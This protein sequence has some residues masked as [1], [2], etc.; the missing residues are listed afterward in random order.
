MSTLYGAV[1]LGKPE[2]QEF[3]GEARK[4]IENY[5]T[6]QEAEKAAEEASMQSAGDVPPMSSSGL[7]Q[8]DFD[9]ATQMANILKDSKNEMLKTEEGRAQYQMGLNELESFLADRKTY[10]R[11]THPVLVQNTKLKK[12]GIT[13]EAWQERGQMDGRNL[14]DY[15]SKTAELDTNRFSV[16]FENGSFVLSDVDGDHTWN[17]PT[18]TDLSWFDESNFLIDSPPIS[19]QSFYNVN[20]PLNEGSVFEDRDAV[21]DYVQREVLKDNSGLRVRD[22]VRWYVNSE[23]NQNSDEPLTFEQIMDP[24]NQNGRERVVAAYAE[25]AV[26]EGWKPTEK[27]S[28]SGSS[29]GSST[30][31]SE[32][33]E[34][35]EVY[36]SSSPDAGYYEVTVEGEKDAYIDQDVATVDMPKVLAINAATWENP[37]VDEGTAAFRVSGMEF[38]AQK[39]FMIITSTGERVKIEAN[40]SEFNKLKTQVDDQLGKGAFDKMYKE[41]KS[42]A[43]EHSGEIIPDMTQWRFDNNLSIN[44]LEQ[45]L[46]T[47]TTEVTAR[48]SEPTKKKERGASFWGRLPF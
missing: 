19:P 20:K 15:I 32:G 1:D 43:L 41:L 24:N 47:E 33:F 2:R 48:P 38:S 16:N 26:D 27:E 21:V 34:M 45:D 30:A 36:R 39:G 12:S 5:V 31:D 4:Q 8:R 18:L 6:L 7:Y 13:P 37:S 10:Y 46:P 40:T 14:E 29:G 25:A 44:G 42:N 23:Q 35:P 9:A 17:D 28:K 3:F 22:A 11:T